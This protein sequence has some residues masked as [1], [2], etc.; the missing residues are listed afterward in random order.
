MSAVRDLK[1]P[2]IQP[3]EKGEKFY[4]VFEEGSVYYE[5]PQKNREC[6]LTPIR[7]LNDDENKNFAELVY[8]SLLKE[9]GIS[10]SITGELIT[11]SKV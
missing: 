5:T 6:L 7:N 3:L 4:L 11:V 9:K 10:V 2:Y 8:S 1:N